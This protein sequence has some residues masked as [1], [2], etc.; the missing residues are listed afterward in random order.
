MKGN[1]RLAWALV[2]LLVAACAGCGK[3]ADALVEEQIR[4]MN[5]IADAIEKDRPRSEIEALRDELKALKE[6]FDE[7]ALTR[8][9]RAAL[10]R[11]Y[12]GELMEAMGR[13][14]RA[15]TK[16]SFLDWKP[17]PEIGGGLLLPGVPLPK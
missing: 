1:R 7:L 3:S 6:K 2:V 12:G 9:Q 5:E 4:V 15:G 13:V 8:E 11:K 17:V 10:E 16:G 14:M